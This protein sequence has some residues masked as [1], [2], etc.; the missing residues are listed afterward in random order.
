M[1]YTEELKPW[2]D[3]LITPEPYYEIAFSCSNRVFLTVANKVFEIGE[4]IN[5]ENP[6][7]HLEE[8]RDYEG[9]LETI[10]IYADIYKRAILDHYKI[11]FKDYKKH[12][13]RL[14]C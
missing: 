4:G 11:D 8:K 7:D 9:D 1:S 13:L 12:A 5:L 14:T 10:V 6:R 2:K 3:L